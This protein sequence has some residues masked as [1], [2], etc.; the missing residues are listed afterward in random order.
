[1]RVETHL[2][3]PL[4]TRIVTPPGAPERGPMVVLFHGFGA[5]GTDL[6]PLAA[7]LGAPNG[8]RFAFPEAPLDLGPAFGG[9]RAWWMIDVVALQMAIASG[10]LRDL[11]GEH[12]AGLDE[13][14]AKASACLDALV[15]AFSPTHLALGGFSQGAMLATHVALLGP[16]SVDALVLFSGSVVAEAAWAPKFGAGSGT[17]V[18]ISHGQLDPVLPYEGA[19]RLRRLFSDAGWKVTFT[20]FRGQHEI[21]AVALSAAGGVLTRAFGAGGPVTE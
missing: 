10:R 14:S 19:E 7:H 17:E 6:V 9:G 8:T 5:P 3:G 2:F 21:P 13:A 18:A 16:R 15:G 4:T 11:A 1:M 12:P 20:P